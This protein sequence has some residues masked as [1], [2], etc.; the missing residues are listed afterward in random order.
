MQLLKNINNFRAY[1]SSG[2]GLQRAKLGEMANYSRMTKVQLVELLEAANIEFP[3]MA[4]VPQLRAICGR[5]IDALRAEV[6]PMNIGAWADT[7]VDALNN[8]APEPNEVAPVLN[9]GAGISDIGS[10]RNAGE[11]RHDKNN[12]TLSVAND[13]ESDVELDRE[14]ARLE[15]LHRI[16]ELKRLNWM[17]LNQLPCRHRFDDKN[18]RF[19]ILKEPLRNLVV[20]I[21]TVSASGSLISKLSWHHSNVITISD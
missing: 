20:T 4:T 11:F 16:Q 13:D 15:K 14:I 6:V 3:L 17:L 7:A 10:E 9:D 19:R 8:A 5:H 2:V 1:Y 21:H 12:A 18:I